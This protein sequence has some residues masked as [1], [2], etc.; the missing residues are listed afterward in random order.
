M[1][2]DEY[3]HAQVMQKGVALWDFDMNTQLL[4]ISTEVA[5]RYNLPK[6]VYVFSDFLKLVPE[7][8]L[9]SMNFE[10]KITEIHMPINTDTE[11]GVVWLDLIVVN[12]FKDDDG[13]MHQVGAVREMTSDEIDTIIDSS[14]VS[15]MEVS[16]LVNSVSLMLEEQ[17]FDAGVHKILE[18]V[19]SQIN[20]ITALVAKWNEDEEFENIDTIGAFLRRENK[21][22]LPHQHLYSSM[23]RDACEMGVDIVAN[24]IQELVNYQREIA[25]FEHN[26]LNSVIVKPILKQD[27]TA[28]GV[29]A[30]SRKR[31]TKWSPFDMNWVS[32]LSRAIS[33]C[34]KHTERLQQSQD[35][36]YINSFACRNTGT[37]TWLWNCVT[38][39]VD[40]TLYN[41]DETNT[42]QMDLEDI[43][44]NTHPDDRA[45]MQSNYDSILDGKTTDF[46]LKVRQRGFRTNDYQWRELHGR[47]TSINPLGDAL[48]VVGTSRDIDQEERVNIAVKKRTDRQN[49]VFNK[50]PVGVAFFGVNGECL[51]INQTNIDL[52][53]VE[54]PISNMNLF[55]DPN[56]TDEQRDTIRNSEQCIINMQYDFSNLE[57]Y[58]KSK[59]EGKRNFTMRISKYYIRGK[60]GGYLSVLT[61]NTDAIMQHQRL[62]E[63]DLYMKEIGS[64]AH[65]GLCFYDKERGFATEQWNENLGLPSTMTYSPD[66]DYFVNVCDDDK[67]LLT[68]QIDELLKGS[69]DTVQMDVR[70]KSTGAVQRWIRL[71]FAINKFSRSIS[72]ISVDITQSKQ[73]ERMLVEARA[74]AEQADALKTQFVAN[75]SHELRTPMN[76]IVGF[77]DLLI[78]S[79]DLEERQ[80]IVDIIH[81]NSELLLQLVSDILDLSRVESGN[82]ELQYGEENANNLCECIHES[83]SMKVPK[84]VDFIYDR[85]N[86]PD[87]TCFVDRRRVTQVVTNFIV[88]AFK[89]T[90][91]GNVKLWYQIENNYLSFHVSDTGKGIPQEQQEHIFETFVK[92]DAFAVGTGLGLAISRILAKKMG[93][94]IQM[95]SEEGVGSHFW[96]TVPIIIDENEAIEKYVKAQRQSVLVAT[97][98]ADTYT[99]IEAALQDECSVMR[100][101]GD[102]IIDEWLEKKTNMIIIDARVAPEKLLENIECMSSSLGKHK[103]FI[104]SDESSAI[105]PEVFLSIGAYKVINFPISKNDFVN[106]VIEE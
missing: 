40:M 31:L 92:L 69:K 5:K 35:Q 22:I 93:G 58:V 50:L 51:Y 24:D 84:D 68:S 44:A 32:L 72:A 76:A 59:S 91:K 99:F 61:D 9:D 16:E 8:Y 96:L 2:N 55:R 36:L 39:V 28:W 54:G 78:Q 13:H 46:K 41:G 79:E 7:E 88:N 60:F 29:M 65:L 38:G 71:H 10:R 45:K 66:T 100:V 90:V 19:N 75:V 80:K 1:T 34:L 37:N 15:S 30:I 47:V 87:V 14:G 64:F 21:E 105:K 62:V 106:S 94:S 52:F 4:T 6:T 67:E 57:G 70:L 73:N 3:I 27:G 77:S 74:R 17:T 56:F 20:G 97:P 48:T 23:L 25:F 98:E 89:F 101:K 49:V 95:E 85:N 53:A 104:I 102:N 82:V 86:A 43:I 12:T 42:I 81:A 26:G 83:M 103:I 18:S 63:L 11:K 33:L